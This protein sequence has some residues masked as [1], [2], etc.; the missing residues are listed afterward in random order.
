[1]R[2]I[3]A[4]K[5]RTELFDADWLTDNDEHM[6]ERIIESQPTV[7]AEPVRHGRWDDSG[8]YRFKDGSVAVRCTACG[9]VLNKDEYI[10]YAWV[11]YP[12]CGA[13]MRCDNENV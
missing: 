5:L 3:D 2:M 11:Y 7:D 6:V 1:M 9:C 4:D 10:K 13:K 12:I 8:R